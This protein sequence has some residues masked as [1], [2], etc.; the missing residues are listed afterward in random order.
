VTEQPETSQVDDSEPVEIPGIASEVS[1]TLSGLAERPVEEH[2][3]VYET[4][5]RRL[6]DTLSDIDHV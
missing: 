3:E 1:Q 6:G 2:P 4:V 5:H